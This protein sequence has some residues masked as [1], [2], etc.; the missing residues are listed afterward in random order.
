VLL[1]FILTVAGVVT[2]AKAD[3]QGELVGTH[4]VDAPASVKLFSGKT[5]VQATM[6][7][8]HG[9]FK[10]SKVDSGS[11]VIHV[12]SD[13]YY[14]QDVPV[15]VA[16]STSHVSITLQPTPDNPSTRA[17][18]DPFRDLDIPR[19]AKKEFE[20]GM[21]EQRDGKCDMRLTHLKKAVALYPRYGEAFTEIA[22]CY[23]VMNEMAAAEDAFKSAIP[24]SPGVYASVNLAT[25]YTN[26]GKVDE[27]QAL[28]TPLL[29]K[30]P[31]EG[32]LYAAL[33]RIHF[34][35]GRLP[36]AE[37]AALEAHRRGHRSPDI[38]LILAKIYEDQGKSGA[39]LTQLQDY[40]DENPRG[41]AADQVRR[42]M[43]ALQRQ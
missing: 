41:A 28:I 33:A 30:N 22:R 25:L 8:A 39:L 6:A 20:L 9:H 29:R 35:K 13:G 10:F 36:E 31:T 14:A 15:Q 42:R 19:A 34:A 23:L 40:L 38:H 5:L 12:E 43:E 3:I 18:F 17:T 4:F 16:N 11:Y 21:R 37:A 7:D 1:L 27:A 26:E 2:P 24:F 32:E